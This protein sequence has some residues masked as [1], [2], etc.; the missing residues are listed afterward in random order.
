M[1]VQH[2]KLKMLLVGD[3]GQIFRFYRGKYHKTGTIS[4]LG[5]VTVSVKIYGRSRGFLV[6]RLVMELFMGPSSLHVNHK[7]GIKADNRL[8]NLEYVS[9]QENNKHAWETGL[10]THNLLDIT[11]AYKTL[12]VSEASERFGLK[13]STIARIW[14]NRLKG[15]QV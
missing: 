8:E 5:Y 4:P 3:D 2:P 14:Q 9:P 6:H 11:Q 13:K 7:N 1:L 12:S 15:V 10:C